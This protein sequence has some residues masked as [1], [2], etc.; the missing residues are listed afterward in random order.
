MTAMSVK[1]VIFFAIFHD[2]AKHHNED[3]FQV[4]EV[5]QRKS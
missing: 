4:K 2:V 1:S 5:E 3:P